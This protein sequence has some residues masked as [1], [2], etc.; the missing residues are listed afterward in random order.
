MKT[1]ARSIAIFLTGCA[2]TTL[3]WKFATPREA[4]PGPQLAPA[5]LPSE[6][7]SWPL[8]KCTAVIKAANEA[9]DSGSR[10]RAML[11]LA[12]IPAGDIPAALE[13]LLDHSQ[14]ESQPAFQTLLIRWASIDGETAINWAWNKLKGSNGWHRAVPEIAASWAWNDPKGF[15][16]WS[17]VSPS[18]TGL[19]SPAEDRAE[20]GRSSAVPVLDLFFFFRAVDVLVSDQPYLAYDLIV[21]RGGGFHGY[22]PRYAKQLETSDQIREAL[23][24]FPDLS[25]LGPHNQS[26]SD[27]AA[28]AV[29]ERWREID[30][31]GFADS[32]HARILP[33][34]PA[35]EMEQ[36]PQIPADERGTHATAM[37]G[38][39]T[40]D[41][42]EKQLGEITRRWAADSP[43][44]AGQW[45]RSLPDAS[46]GYP[47][48]AQV[49]APHHLEGTLDW[50][51]SLPAPDRAAAFAQSFESWQAAHPGTRPDTSDWSTTRR[52]AWQDMETL[53]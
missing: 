26:D 37:L 43:A 15:H 20:L 6:P 8:E 17:L 49:R 32:P 29:L 12:K 41:A 25:H 44:E 1:S 51:D 10:Y 39:L 38:N 33:P 11:D 4:D 36:W 48:F 18:A 5:P 21:Q 7:A 24:A 40:T 30:P 13:T 14:P 19:G 9:E 50:T 35:R 34:D 28:W 2:A 23:A 46:A 22:Y 47:V 16:R 27:K 45:L 52:Q 31:K 53:E 42:R 3:V